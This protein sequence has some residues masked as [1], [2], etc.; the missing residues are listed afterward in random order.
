MSQ[1]LKIMWFWRNCRFFITM[2]LCPLPLQHSISKTSVV[3]WNPLWHTYCYCQVDDSFSACNSALLNAPF[4]PY[5]LRCDLSLY[6]ALVNKAVAYVSKCFSS[7]Q[8]LTEC[9]LSWYRRLLMSVWFFDVINTRQAERLVITHSSVLPQQHKRRR[10]TSCELL[11]P[12]W[13]T[14]L[15]N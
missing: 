8:L 11:F 2:K 4:T 7:P 14:I 13:G 5:L 15:G 3:M 12:G 6:C 9:T 10:E 1:S